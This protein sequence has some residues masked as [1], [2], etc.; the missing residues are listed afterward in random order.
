MELMRSMKANIDFG[1]PNFNQQLMLRVLQSGCLKEHF[2]DA[3]F[4]L[5]R[6]VRGHAFGL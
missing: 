2:G 5:S 3:S 4:D 1:S 6:E